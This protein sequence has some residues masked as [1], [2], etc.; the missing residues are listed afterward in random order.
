M[1]D[2]RPTLVVIL[3][4]GLLA[5]VI[6]AEAQPPR[7]AARIGIVS[8]FEP[9]PTEPT[10][11]AFRHGLRDLGWV[12]GQTIA[13][14]YR[15]A[16]GRRELYTKLA[17]ELVQLK[18]DVLVVGGAGA[19][20]ARD[21]TKTI[22]IVFVGAGGDPV[23]SGLVA[24]LA[25]PG[26]NLTGLSMLY[27]VEFVKKGVQLLKEAA[28]SIARVGILRDAGWAGAAQWLPDLRAAAQSLGLKSQDLPVR[29]LHELNGVFAVMSKERGGSLYVVTTPLFYRNR[30]D[31]SLITELAAK[32]RLPVIYGW[33]EFVDEGG[34]MSYGPSSSDLWRRAASYVDKILKG[35]RPTDLPVEQPTK[36]D[37][38]V[39]LK[40]A[41]ALALTV[42][43]G[44][45][46]R[47]DQ[48]IEK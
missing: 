13:L 11:V 21:A 12:E 33:R 29:D 43:P 37:L 42:P 47:A 31:R 22:P 44:V 2:G 15:Y 8:S 3:A 19:F 39:N 32:H 14:E 45:L 20:A 17:A 38:V 23:A 28:P 9:S 26:G 27:D 34:L 24:S 41:K 48:V 1:V 4:L 46:A 18:V 7:T 25:R 6:G 5:M 16:H 35:A 30:A 10:V 36:F 40:T